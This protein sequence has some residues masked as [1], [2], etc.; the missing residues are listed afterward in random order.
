MPD[1][2]SASGNQL[3]YI[4][5]AQRKRGAHEQLRRARVEPVVD[6]SRVLTGNELQRHGNR[7][8]KCQ[9]TDADHER[10]SF[11]RE[12]RQAQEHERPD[13]EEL[14]AYAQIP[15]VGE[16]RGEARGV[17]IGNLAEDIGPVAYKQCRGQR[18]GLQLGQQTGACGVDRERREC[19]CCKHGRHKPA[20]AFDQVAFVIKRSGIFKL[21]HHAPGCKVAREH[22]E[23]G[24]A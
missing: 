16:G 3:L 14:H 11:M 19:D 2:V 4:G 15:Q 22:E 9:C 10:L 1:Q 23:Q 24:D 7:R 13:D 17:E 12:L 5:K 6:T 8:E 20:Q 18:I 21:V